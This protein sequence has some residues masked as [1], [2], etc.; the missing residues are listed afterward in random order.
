MRRFDI[1]PAVTQPAQ[2]AMRDFSFSQRAHVVQY[3]YEYCNLADL[4]VAVLLPAEKVHR[5]RDHDQDAKEHHEEHYGQHQLYRQRHVGRR[6]GR[7]LLR[8]AQCGLPARRQYPD[9]Y[10]LIRFRRGR[11]N[12]GL[13][14]DRAEKG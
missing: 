12:T 7:E 14:S 3:F 6:G 1:A 13:D 2:V 4:A 5:V 9:R 8:G 11:I 10:V